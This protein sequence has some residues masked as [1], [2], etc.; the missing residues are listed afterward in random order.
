MAELMLISSVDSYTLTY[1][2]GKVRS[3]M[4]RSNRLSKKS[5]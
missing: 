3:R 4:R 1:G 5:G 2:L